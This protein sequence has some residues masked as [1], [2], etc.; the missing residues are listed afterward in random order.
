MVAQCKTPLEEAPDFSAED[1][2]NW[3]ERKK[4]EVVKGGGLE[5]Y[6]KYF[7][8]MDKYKPLYGKKQ[9]IDRIS[10]TPSG[11]I[12]IRETKKKDFKE[13]KYHLITPGGERLASIRT[14]AKSVIISKNFVLYT[15]EDENEDISLYCMK[16]GGN[17]NESLLKLDRKPGAVRNS[18]TLFSKSL[19][20]CLSCLTSSAP[21][22]GPPAAY[23][24]E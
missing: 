9:V 13:Y 21:G 11:N 24:G 1:L 20:E 2:Q 16:V 17:D 14:G 7:T 15:L 22:S 19:C 3:R 23:T 18:M 4:K 5:F 10:T 8:V 6:K 12:L